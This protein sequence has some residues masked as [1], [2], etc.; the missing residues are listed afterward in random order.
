MPARLTRSFFDRPCIE[1]APEL[2][3]CRLV[4]QLGD[5]TRLSGRIVEVEAYLGDGSDPGSHS[6]NGQTARNAA[7]FGAPGVFYV[8]RSMG[9]HACANVVCEP[10]G[11]GAAVLLR[12]VEPV[13]GIEWMQQQRDNRPE[14]ELTNGP[15]KLCQAFG[16]RLDHDGHSAL[17]GP[18]R[19]LAAE[20]RPEKIVR[21]PRIGIVKG[22][23][24]WQRF[25][26]ADS[27]WVSSSPLNR[28]ARSLPPIMAEL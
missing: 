11:S 10:N 28:R 20:R 27:P 7:M 3:G 18:L 2:L 12:A 9:I 8:Y 5:G 13:D 15:G 25:F 16:I 23:D 19:L 1:V 26:V 6:H 17:R 24:L 4:H 14:R 22:A 21:S